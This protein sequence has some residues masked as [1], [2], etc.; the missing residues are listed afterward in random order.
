M[1]TIRKTSSVTSSVLR[2]SCDISFSSALSLFLRLFFAV[3]H[4]NYIRFAL[5]HILS[6]LY[7][8]NKRPTNLHF[9][10]LDPIVCYALFLKRGIHFRSLWSSSSERINA[11]DCSWHIACMHE[12][13]ML[14]VD[15]RDTL[16]WPILDSIYPHFSH[17]IQ[18]NMFR[19]TLNRIFRF[20]LF[21]FQ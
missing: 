16:V 12:V 10:K 14:S 11:F 4:K 5:S 13:V 20:P 19:E 3:D 21:L 2:H 1:K 6:N 8:P 9:R 18:I 7:V 15:C 17:T